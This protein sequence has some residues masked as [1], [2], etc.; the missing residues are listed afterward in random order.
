MPKGKALNGAVI[1]IS[2]TLSK[3]RKEVEADIAA[4]GGKAGS[5]VTATTTLLVTTD[6]EYASGA[7]VTS[8]VAAAKARGIPCV[9]ESYLRACLT[10]GSLAST[11][12]HLVTGSGLATAGTKRK[13]VALGGRPKAAKAAPAPAKLSVTRSFSS[14]R[15]VE[16]MA[17]SR[18]LDCLILGNHDHHTNLFALDMA[19]LSLRAVKGL[20]ELETPFPGGC[21]AIGET[22]SD[23]ESIFVSEHRY[24]H[25]LE[26]GIQGGG[27]QGGGCI[28]AEGDLT[29]TGPMQMCFDGAVDELW[30]ARE[31]HHPRFVCVLRGSTGKK[32][33]VISPTALWGPG[34][35]SQYFVRTIAGLALSDEEVFVATEHGVKVFSRGQR[36]SAVWPPMPAGEPGT[37]VGEESKQGYVYR[38]ELKVNK[39]IDHLAGWNGQLVLCCE[40]AVRILNS[41]GKELCKLPQRGAKC[42]AICGRADGDELAVLAGNGNIHFYK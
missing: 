39:R 37:E 14:S 41:T 10:K 13:T 5:S 23:R 17:Y 16:F 7:S 32:V 4:A 9:Y 35:D 25:I 15:K 18:A 28:G 6:A 2:G 3:P 38:R 11:G 40:D 26:W 8:K 20:G 22:A 30:V 42:A 33:G 31:Q 29:M 21:I 27:I 19:T 24:D 34:Q 12:P 36:E 1:A